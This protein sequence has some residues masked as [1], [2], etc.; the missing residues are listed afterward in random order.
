MADVW[1]MA[2]QQDEAFSEAWFEEFSNKQGWYCALGKE[3]PRII[4]VGETQRAAFNHAWGKK[5][6]KVKA[7]VTEEMEN[8]G[9]DIDEVLERRGNRY[10]EYQDVSTTAQSLKY[11]FHNRGSWNA[12]EPYMQESLDMICN[13]LSRIA[14]GDPYYDDSW[15]DIAGYATLVVKELEKGK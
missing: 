7:L 12:M 11:E 4:G 13:K 5:M 1:S 3:V 9:M 14:N 2:Q 8:T 6:G 10:G 15:R